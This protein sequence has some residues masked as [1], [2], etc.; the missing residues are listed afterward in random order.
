MFYFA[1][2]AIIAAL[3]LKIKKWV[4]NQ[5]NE[6]FPIELVKGHIH[7]K[8]RI[9]KGLAFNILQTKTNISRILS[10][11][12]FAI[13]F[14]GALKSFFVKDGRIGLKLGISLILGGGLS[15]TIERIRSGKVT[16]YISFP[17]FP[18]KSLR[19]VVYNLGDLA[20][21]AGVI[22]TFF[23]LLSGAKKDD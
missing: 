13:V 14:F 3:D 12:S 11:V 9:N 20:I 7:I 21:F 2:A 15:N 16:D 5:L 23:S 19:K 8:R 4:S 17:K 22:I 6:S 18:I 1:I 10:V